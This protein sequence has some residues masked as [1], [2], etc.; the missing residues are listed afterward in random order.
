MT[1]RTATTGLWVLYL[2]AC[3]KR[4][5]VNK[6]VAQIEVGTY[7][8]AARGLGL[9]YAIYQKDRQMDRGGGI[10]LLLV[11]EPTTEQAIL[12]L[13]VCNE[14]KEP[15]R[16]SDHN[17]I[18]FALEFEREKMESDV[19]VFQLS[20]VFTMEDSSSIPE[21]QESQGAEL[22][23]LA[24]TKEKVLVKPK[25]LKVDK[26]PQPDGKHPRVLKEIAEEIVEA[27]VVIFKESLESGKVL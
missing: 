16:G 17:M 13:V 8:V 20:K 2:N 18:E 14:A 6:L 15:L 23:I 22:S 11:A 1:R 9:G 25:G 4:N 24:I 19:T 26:S 12:D 10:A 7:D 21:L 27:L 5:Q 3:S